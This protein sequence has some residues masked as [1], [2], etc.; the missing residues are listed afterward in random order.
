MIF[1]QGL[2]FDLATFLLF[3]SDFYFSCHKGYYCINHHT[4]LSKGVVLGRLWESGALSSSQHGGETVLSASYWMI[5]F[6]PPSNAG[7]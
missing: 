6:N 4:R 1:S 3:Q 2:L 5:S 7:G